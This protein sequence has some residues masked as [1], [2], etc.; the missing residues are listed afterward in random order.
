MMRD[1]SHFTSALTFTQVLTSQQRQARQYLPQL[2]VKLQKPADKA[3]MAIALIFLTDT[4][5]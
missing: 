1:A 2:T 5:I 3:D 4:T